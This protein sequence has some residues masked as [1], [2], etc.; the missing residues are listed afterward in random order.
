[1]AVGKGAGSSKLAGPCLAGVARERNVVGRSSRVGSSKGGQPTPPQGHGAMQ[2]AAQDRIQGAWEL[3]QNAVRPCN[4][5]AKLRREA[6]M[7]WV[8]VCFIWIFGP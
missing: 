1:M 2:I 5:A 4:A 3:G 6:G 7:A 8:T